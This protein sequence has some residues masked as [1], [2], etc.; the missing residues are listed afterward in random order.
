MKFFKKKK[1]SSKSLVEIFKVGNTD[2]IGTSG[3]LYKFQKWYHKISSFYNLRSFK[4]VIIEKNCLLFWAKSVIFVI[5]EVLPLITRN[6][7]N[8]RKI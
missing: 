2:L 8:A 5:T 1:K 7:Y 6:Y 4:S 3:K